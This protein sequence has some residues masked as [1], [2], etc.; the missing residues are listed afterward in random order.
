MQHSTTRTMGRR[1]DSRESIR[2]ND[3]ASQRIKRMRE[4]EHKS[5]KRSRNKKAGVSSIFVFFPGC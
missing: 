1:K 3:S 2:P 4:Q 5:R